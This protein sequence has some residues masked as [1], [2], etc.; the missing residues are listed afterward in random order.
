MR[1]FADGTVLSVSVA[2]SDSINDDWVPD[3][4]TRDWAEWQK[5]SKGT[6][7]LQ[8][9]RITFAIAVPDGEVSYD[10]RLRGSSIRARWR[11]TATNR[12]GERTYVF[13]PARRTGTV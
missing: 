2:L 3:W 9:G 1:Y 12:S 13:R 4:L 5:Y 10:A 7:T 11:S 6:Y 8:Q